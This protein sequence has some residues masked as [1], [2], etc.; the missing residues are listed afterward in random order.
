VVA[1]S[2]DGARVVQWLGTAINST[3]ELDYRDALDWLGLRFA[4]PPPAPRAWLGVRTRVEGMR[5]I[6]AEVRRGS[7]A[8]DAGLDINDELVSL[9]DVEIAGKLADRLAP[10][11]PGSRVTFGIVRRGARESVVVTLAS[12]PAQNWS[13]AVVS[14]PTKD[15]SG[16]LR[17]WLGE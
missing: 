16:H 13:L 5:T 14:T 6:V 3:Q 8:A 10:C 9:N 11:A 15:Q 12:D 4:P 7:P 1:G 2:A 17:A